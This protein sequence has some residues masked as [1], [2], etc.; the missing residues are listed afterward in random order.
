VR[1]APVRTCV[2]CRKRAPASELV[3]LVLVQDRPTV[4]ARR[5]LPGRGASLHANEVCVRAALAQGG[6][7]RAFRRRIVVAAPAE[8][9]TEVM[10]AWGELA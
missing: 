2:G 9:L 3:R 4:D 1:V 7:G 5:A 10:A 8:L 6:F